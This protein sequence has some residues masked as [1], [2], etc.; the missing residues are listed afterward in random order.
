MALVYAVFGAFVAAS[1]VTV[2]FTMAGVTNK[3]STV[4]RASVQ[5]RY[6][7][8]GAIAAGMRDVRVAVANWNDPPATGSVTVGDTDVNYSITPLGAPQVQVDISGIQTVVQPYELQAVANV[9]GYRASA[10]RIVHSASTPLFQFAV[11][12]TNDLEVSPGPNMTLGGR[13]HTNGNMYLGSGA[14]LTLDTNHVRAVGDIFRRRKHN[15]ESAG[16]VDIRKWVANP[17]DPSEPREFFRMNSRGQMGSVA[18]PSGYDSAFTSGYDHNGDGDFWDTN[19]WLPFAPGALEYW[20]A[21]EGYGGGDGHTVLTGEHGVTEAMTPGNASLAMYDA[22]DGGSYALDSSTGEYEYVGPGLGT[23]DPGYYHEHAGLK[24]IVDASGT[25]FTALNA[26]GVDVTSL[27]GGAVTLGSV[28]DMR[29]SSSQPTR[30]PVVQVDLAL[31]GASGQYPANGLLY[32]AHYGTGEGVQAKGLLLTN[33]SELAAPLTAVAEGSVYLQGDYNTVNKKGA[34]A[35]GDAVNLLSNNWTGNKQPGQ[36]PGASETT[37]NCAFVTGNYATEGSNYNGGL[38]NLPRYH[39]NWNGVPCNITGSFVN[40]FESQYA[41][42]HWAYGGDRYTAP[43]RN[44][45]YDTAFNSAANLPP[46]T[47]MAVSVI[48]VVSW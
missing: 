25:S 47:P 39:E 22:M 12:Y 33:G 19:D 36:L 46:F 24:I 21:P 35:I 41:T 10:Q 4:K 15:G 40:M 17:F 6:L 31:L 13:V 3:T 23:H 43:I 48:E 1:M 7:A 2:M 14:T 8:E 34:A 30:V 42:A 29:Q 16:N 11:F 38:E 26:D 18:T 32:S 5:A 28:P 44:W 9:N 20:G 27:L 45:A 37:F